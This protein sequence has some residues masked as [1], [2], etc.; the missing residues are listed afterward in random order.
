M[1]VSRHGDLRGTGLWREN[2]VTKACVWGEGVQPVR[3]CGHYCLLTDQ[4]AR[5]IEPIRGEAIDYAH[6]RT[7]DS[8][9]PTSTA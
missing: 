6:T 9:G 4:Y 2:G 7:F 5:A 8:M 1:Q 3:A